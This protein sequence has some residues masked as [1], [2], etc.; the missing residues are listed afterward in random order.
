MDTLKNNCQ[1]SDCQIMQIGFLLKGRNTKPCRG[2]V[3]QLPTD[4]SPTIKKMVPPYFGSL[5]L[6]TI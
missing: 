1:L 5:P 3:N 4:D 6:Y 2:K